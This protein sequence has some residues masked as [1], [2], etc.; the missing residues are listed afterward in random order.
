LPDYDL[1]EV[2]SLERALAL[3][4]EEPGV[5]KPFAGGTDLMVAF[6]AG[7]LEHHRFLSL[8]NLDELRAVELTPEHLTLGALTTYTQVLSIQTLQ[9]EFPAL[10]RAAAETGAVAIQNRG[11][12]G[13][14]LANAS[15][16]A[17]SPPALLV[18]DAQV[19]LSSAGGSRWVPYADFHTGYRQTL[20]RREEVLTRIRLPRVPGPPGVHYYR[21]VGTRRAQAI[22]KTC[23]A[24]FARLDGGRV[25]SLRVALGA[26]APTPVRCPKTE[27]LLA[28][29]P[30]TSSLIAEAAKTLVTEIAPI[31]DFRSTARYRAR[32][33]ANLLTEFLQSLG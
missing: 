7:R 9:R 30:F 10:C 19:E 8:W 32:V 13:G 1:V 33:S 15:P 21:K 24:G 29:R 31:D 6:E 20:L 17:D 12:L 28:G 3:L 5:W 18:Y 11:T 4:G 2:G 23:L 25:E 22:S 27:A 14:N 16:A 26:V